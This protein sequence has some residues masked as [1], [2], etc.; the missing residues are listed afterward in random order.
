M[1]IFVV[2][3]LQVVAA[4]KYDCIVIGAGASGLSTVFHLNASGVDNVLVLEAR[5]RVGGRIHTHT[6][7]GTSHRVELGAQWLEHVDVN[8]LLNEIPTGALRPRYVHSEYGFSLVTEREGVWSEARTQ[9]DIMWGV[10]LPLLRLLVSRYL[11]LLP[12]VQPIPSYDDDV[13]LATLVDELLDSA[14]PL[15]LSANELRML[16]HNAG[17]G[18]EGLQLHEQSLTTLLDPTFDKRPLTGASALPRDGYI[19]TLQHLYD[20]FASKIELSTSVTKIEHSSDG[21]RVHTSG[22]SVFEGRACVSTLPL[23]VLK[24]GTIEFTPPLSVRKREA[25][26]RVGVGVVNRASLLFASNF[27]SH[28]HAS[29]LSELF[30]MLADEPLQRTCMQSV[31]FDVSRI[32]GAPVLS[33]IYAGA[34]HTRACFDGLSDTQIV[35]S[36]MRSLRRFLPAA[37][38]PLD[39]VVTRWHDDAFAR[40]AYSSYTRRGVNP[41]IGARFLESEQTTLFFAGE[42]TWYTEPGYVHSAWYSGHCAARR[43]LGGDE[44]VCPQPRRRP[45]ALMTAALWSCSALAGFLVAYLM[46]ACVR[47]CRERGQIKNKPE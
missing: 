7:A 13:S 16:A 21:C 38:T 31:I 11:S 26:D 17:T 33:A 24:H 19:S 46:R 2:T 30:I 39:A 42:H 32:N 18:L 34:Q 37:P 29:N 27:W 47:R 3:L 23:G 15:P 35:D 10:G 9:R 45:W 14:A 44:A 6:F 5:N 22:G 25:I 41:S 20:A 36:V 1:I 28:L 8:P 43:L 40:G 4:T 12:W